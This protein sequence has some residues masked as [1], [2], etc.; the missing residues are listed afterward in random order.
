MLRAG[1]DGFELTESKDMGQFGLVQAARAENTAVFDIDGDAKEELLIADKNY[2]R[3][4]RYE[5]APDPGVSPGWQ[6]VRQM[7]AKDSSS[8]LVS[9]AVL[10]NRVVVADK[11]NDR[12]VVMAASDPAVQGGAW[13]EHESVNVQGFSFSSIHAGA[14]SGDGQDNILAIGDDGFA[15]IRFGGERLAL[16]EI[17]AW[18]T[19]DERRHQHEL[20]PGDING[21]GYIDMVCLDAGEQMCEIFTFSDTGTMHYVTGFKVYESKLFS[22]GETREFEPSQAIIADVT[23]DDANDMILLSHDRVL[24]Y[25]QMVKTP[26]ASRSE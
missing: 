6:V 8:K 1:D 24:I 14:F 9:L 23:G 16:K 10:G 25:P 11:E 21:D 13:A 17:S 22:G 2:V 5:P 7:N 20:T 4:V 26:R 12:L 3:A 15:V 19:T 18:R